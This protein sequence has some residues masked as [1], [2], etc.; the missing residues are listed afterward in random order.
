[1]GNPVKIYDL[2]KLL[3][4]LSGFSVFDEKTGTGDIKIKIIGI[5]PGEKLHEELLIGDN[6]TD[7]AHPR[8]K[9]ANEEFLPWP[10][11]SKMLENL[12]TAINLDNKRLLKSYLDELVFKIKK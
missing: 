8:I 6:V 4:K 1:M 2:A 10:K 9:F 11:M 7:S 12:S 3:I 5:R